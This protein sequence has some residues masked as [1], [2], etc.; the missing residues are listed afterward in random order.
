M[1]AETSTKN[2]V[3]EFHLRTVTGT[4]KVTVTGTGIATGK[5]YRKRDWGT[6]RDRNRVGDR[7]RDQDVG[8]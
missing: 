6:D 1:P 4:R 8:K 3:Q 5:R 2:A 7:N